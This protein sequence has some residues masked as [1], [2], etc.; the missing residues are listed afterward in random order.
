MLF[1]CHTHATYENAHKVRVGGMYVHQVA[2]LVGV[3][4]FLMKIT[5]WRANERCVGDWSG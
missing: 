4:V 3:A 2:W 1:I 5:R